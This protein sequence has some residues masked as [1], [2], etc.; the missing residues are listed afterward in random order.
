VLQW[1]VSGETAAGINSPPAAKREA[2]NLLPG[3]LFSKTEV[4]GPHRATRPKVYR[5]SS[6]V[7]HFM[8][9]MTYCQVRWSSSRLSN[10]NFLFRFQSLPNARHVRL[11]ERVAY[12]Q[13]EPCRYSQPPLHLRTVLC[14]IGFRFV[15]SIELLQSHVHF[16]EVSN[17]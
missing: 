16:R 7:T 9:L 6:F 11:P 8:S 15:P 13:S 14:R 4:F 17:A 5:S 12:R 3:A 1:N 10:H 2:S